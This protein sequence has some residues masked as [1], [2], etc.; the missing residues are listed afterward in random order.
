MIKPTRSCKTKGRGKE[1]KESQS[2]NMSLCIHNAYEKAKRKR[3][4]AIDIP[5]GKLA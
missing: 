4:T 2:S 1:R 5:D 3:I